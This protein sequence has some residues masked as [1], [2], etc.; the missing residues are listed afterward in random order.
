MGIEWHTDQSLR[1]KTYPL[2]NLNFTIDV[3]FT[4]LC[5]MV[6]RYFVGHL[7]IKSTVVRLGIEE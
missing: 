5:S 7:L 6:F 2:C 4:Q 1:R 3:D